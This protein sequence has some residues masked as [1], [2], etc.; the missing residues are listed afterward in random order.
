MHA[1]ILAVVTLLLP[2]FSPIAVWV[3]P[4]GGDKLKIINSPIADLQK[5]WEPLDPGPPGKLLP[6]IDL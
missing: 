2:L 3:V 4:S 6:G 5:R 1:I